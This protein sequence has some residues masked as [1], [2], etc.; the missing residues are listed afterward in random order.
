ML[1][2][3]FSFFGLPPFLVL[4]DLDWLLFDVWEIADCLGDVSG[5]LPSGMVFLFELLPFRLLLLDDLD[6]T[7]MTV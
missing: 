3:F 4:S 5:L 2:F 1:S 6:E 7:D